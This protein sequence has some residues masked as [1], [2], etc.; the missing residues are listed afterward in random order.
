MGYRIN[1][2]PRTNAPVPADDVPADVD[3]DEYERSLLRREH[4]W[5]IATLALGVVLVGLAALSGGPLLLLLGVGLVARG[6]TRWR[7]TGTALQELA[8]RDRD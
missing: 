5:A 3:L 7:S 2:P 8:V 4:R 6:A 1:D